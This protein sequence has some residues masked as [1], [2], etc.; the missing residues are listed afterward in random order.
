MNE[1]QTA[2]L[3][4]VILMASAGAAVLIRPLLSERHRSRDTIELVQL[5]VTMMVTFAALVLGLLTSSAKSSFD[6]VE[7]DIRGYAVELIQ[8]NRCLRE[9]GPET[10]PT[11]ALLRVYTA[12]A[13]ATTWTT[14]PPPPGDYYP[15]TLPVSRFGSRIESSALATVLEQ[16]EFSVRRLNPAD[17]VQRSLAAK[18]V[19]VFDALLQQRWK[20]IQEAHPSIAQPFYVVLVFWLGVVFLSFGLTTPRNALAFTILALGAVSIASVVFVILELD[21][22]FGGFIAV[23][24]EPLRDALV[25]MSG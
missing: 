11:R 17:P 4:F 22:P 9:Y 23:P 3:L 21:T 24:S 2:V 7:T 10:E 6:T 25:H 5:V 1:W 13:I 8:L 16:I 18:C 19:S 20:V 14:E 15:T 12:A